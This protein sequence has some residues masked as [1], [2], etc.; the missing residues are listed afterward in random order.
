MNEREVLEAKLDAALTDLDVRVRNL[1]MIKRTLNELTACVHAA[2]AD[3]ERP[4][5]AMAMRQHNNKGKG[6]R[7][8]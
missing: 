6:K 8:I 2:V 5:P 1:E 3:M 7:E 4:P